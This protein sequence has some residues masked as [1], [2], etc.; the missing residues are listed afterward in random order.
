M[1]QVGRFH[2][3]YLIKCDALNWTKTQIADDLIRRSNLSADDPEY[4]S[5]SAELRPEPGIMFR[6]SDGSRLII[7]TA[8]C[9]VD[10]LFII[11]QI[12]RAPQQD[13]DT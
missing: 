3:E 6:F 11:N 12:S 1:N 4:L 7:P 8:D 2:I 10:Q 5:R 9:T 13:S